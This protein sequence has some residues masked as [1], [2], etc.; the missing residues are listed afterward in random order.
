MVRASTGRHF[1]PPERLGGFEI[2]PM[3][4]VSMQNLPSYETT[5]EKKMKMA[6][7]KVGQLFK[8][9]YPCFALSLILC[10]ISLL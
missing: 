3:L 5:W 8:I 6:L 2:C 7:Q 10:S 4:L 1:L 9:R